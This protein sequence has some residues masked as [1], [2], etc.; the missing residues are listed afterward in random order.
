MIKTQLSIASIQGSPDEIPVNIRKAI[1][2]HKLRKL[3][4]ELGLYPTMLQVS[5]VKPAKGKY[6]WNDWLLFWWD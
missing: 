4:N 5:P 3:N 1:Y 6:R 2:M